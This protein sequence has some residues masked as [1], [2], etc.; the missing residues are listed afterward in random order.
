GWNGMDKLSS[1]ARPVIRSFQ[2]LK[3]RPDEVPNIARELDRSSFCPDIPNLL[4]TRIYEKHVLLEKRKQDYSIETDKA[5]KKPRK[6]KEPKRGGVLKAG[7]EVSKVEKKLE[8]SKEG[9]DEA[10]KKLEVI[11][12]KM[13]EAKKEL[14]VAEHGMLSPTSEAQDAK[15]NLKNAEERESYDLMFVYY[16]LQ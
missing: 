2:I 6:I 14:K 10:K 4:C 12:N 8:E 9:V 1:I 7:E 16:R 15:Q 11:E 13:R 5:S 3:P